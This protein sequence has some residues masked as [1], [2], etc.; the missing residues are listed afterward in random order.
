MN[1]LVRCL[2]PHWSSAEV[3]AAIWKLV[4]D[5][6]AEGRLLVDLAEVELSHEA[7]L[8]LLPP[9]SCPILPEPLPSSL[10]EAG[11]DV[12]LIPQAD[13]GDLSLDPSVGIPGS[14]FDA[15]A[16][17]TSEEQVRFHRNLAAATAVLAGMSLR[18]VSEAHGIPRATLGRLVSRTK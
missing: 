2:G 16:L 7:S 18:T 4:G 15:S 8:A 14:T 9:E 13:E 5:A 6:A 10:E 3:K 1:E 12:V 17:A 11:F